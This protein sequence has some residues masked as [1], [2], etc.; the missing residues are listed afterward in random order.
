MRFK[1]NTAKKKQKLLKEISELKF[2]DCLG[3]IVSK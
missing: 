2:Y 1:E 3:H